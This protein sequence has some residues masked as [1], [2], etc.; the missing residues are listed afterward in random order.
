VDGGES[1]DGAVGDGVWERTEAVHDEE[2]QAVMFECEGEGGEAGIV[3]YEAV[4]HGFQK[5][6]AEEEGC[7]AAGYGC[8]CGYEPSAQTSAHIPAGSREIGTYP[9]GKP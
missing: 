8:G 7:C 1:C 2:F 9:F 4:D 5:G 6:S 3:R